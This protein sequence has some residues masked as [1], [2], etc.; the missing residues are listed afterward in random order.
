MLP[1]KLQDGE[2]QPT[3]SI[4]K[5]N[6][7]LKQRRFQDTEDVNKNVTVGLNAVP[8][9]TFNDCFVQLLGKT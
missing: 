5:L 7:A 8:L 2:C 3:V 9:D 1:G 4:P 6:T